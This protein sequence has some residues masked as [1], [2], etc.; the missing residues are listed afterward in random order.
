[1]HLFAQLINSIE[2]RSRQYLRHVLLKVAGFA[3]EEIG[4]SFFWHHFSPCHR[5]TLAAHPQLKQLGAR[6]KSPAKVADSQELDLEGMPIK[7]ICD[8][9]EV[10]HAKI[11]EDFD[12][13]NPVV[14]LINRMRNHGIPAD[15]M[16]IDCLK[17][18][19]R[20]LLMVHDSQ[21]EIASYQFCRRDEDPSDEFES[22]AIKSLTAQKLYDWMKDTFSTED[23]E[24]GL[25]K[26]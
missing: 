5:R 10:A 18:G 6:L 25:C 22:I 7:H 13:I 17:S 3:V 8:A 9:V 1:M 12:N 14:G 4:C 26:G 21:P 19:K 20:I 24:E 16:T 23:S 2:R 11:Q 15:L